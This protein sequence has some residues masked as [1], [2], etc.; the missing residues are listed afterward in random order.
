MEIAPVLLAEATQMLILIAH[1]GWRQ[2]SIA[3][4]I[5]HSGWGIH[6]NLPGPGLPTPLSS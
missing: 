5:G 2:V 6:W 1:R 3:G 4:V